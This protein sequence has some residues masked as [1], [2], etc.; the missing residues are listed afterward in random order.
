MAFCQIHDSRLCGDWVSRKGRAYY[1]GNA[2]KGC[3]R[4]LSLDTVEKN[5]A[6]HLQKIQCSEK[7]TN[8][9]IEKAKELI[10]RSREAK[11]QEIENIRN[12]IKQLEVKRNDIEDNLLDGTI[13]KEAFKRK[14]GELDVQIQN[15]DNEIATMENQGGLDV[16]AVVEIVNLMRNLKQKYEK[17]SFEAKRH[18]LSMFF[19]KLRFDEV[20]NV[21]KTDYS[22]LFQHLVDNQFIRISA[23]W[24]RVKDSDLQPHS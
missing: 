22:L 9:V 12:A 7:L 11:Q 10:K 17:A 21:V 19:E 23:N 6:K 8:M 3:K 20:G 15:Y 14:H 24:L 2:N 1:H 18:Y 4:Y 13:D 16:N 5:I